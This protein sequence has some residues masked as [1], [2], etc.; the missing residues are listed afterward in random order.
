[1]INLRYCLYK[2]YDA[3]IKEHPQKEMNRLGITYKLAVPQSIADQW[4]FL[5]CEN[6]PEPLPPYLKRIM[7]DVTDFKKFIGNG[8]SKEDAEMLN[9]ELA[10]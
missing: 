6:L 7:E 9:Q 2:S 10:K 3:Q 1:M 4:W 8:L 5:G